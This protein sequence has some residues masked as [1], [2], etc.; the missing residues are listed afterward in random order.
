ML[1]VG[2]DGFVVLFD[3]NPRYRLS[4]DPLTDTVVLS[5]LCVDSITS[6]LSVPV[7]LSSPV[8]LRLPFEQSVGTLCEHP[9]TLWRS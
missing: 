3:R 4:L 6:L 8:Y 5:I 9:R 7:P 2:E 1:E